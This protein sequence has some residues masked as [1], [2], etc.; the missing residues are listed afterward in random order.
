MSSSVAPSAS[1]R[2][3]SNDL[4]LGQVVAVRE[5]D[6]RPDRHIRALEDRRR[7]ANVGRPDAHRRDVVLGGQPAAR[8]RRTRRRVRVAAASGRWSWRYRARSGNRWSGS[9]DSLDVGTQ[10][11]AGQQEAALDELVGL[12]EVAILVLDDH[13]AVVAGAP[14]GGEQHAPVDVAEPRQARDLPADP[15]REDRRARTAPRGRS[16]GPWPGRA[17][18][19]ARTPG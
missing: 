19:A 9:W 12:L 10:D 2:W 18:C 3:A 8:R 16:T 7:P 11:V 4:G 15:E 14:Q 17:G 5:P 6:R 1:A 13:V